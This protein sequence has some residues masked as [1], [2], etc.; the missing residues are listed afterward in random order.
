MLSSVKFYRLYETSARLLNKVFFKLLGIRITRNPIFGDEIKEV[1]IDAFKTLSSV[2]E[3][4]MTDENR[5]YN[6][7]LATRYIV[8]NKIEGD[9]VECGVWRG[10]SMMAIALTLLQSNASDRH[11]FLYDTFQGMTAPSELDRRLSGELA[12]QL[13]IDSKENLQ[14]EYS[15]GIY[16]YASIEDV[17]SGMNETTYPYSLIHFIEGK[18]EETLLNCSHNKISL[19]RLDTDWYESTKVELECLWDC[20]VVG[21]VLILDD[22]DHWAGARIATD[23]FFLKK[24]IHPLLMKM[25][26]GRILIKQS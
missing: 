15:Q 11:L 5:L 22:Y 19:L 12:S 24:G 10:G 21:G 8:Q 18:V 23:E 26:A 2:M 14:G 25:A 16:A 17:K 13:L 1:D 20:L 9:F 7:I 6:L 4:T 3:R